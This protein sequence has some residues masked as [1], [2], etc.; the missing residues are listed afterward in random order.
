LPHSQSRGLLQPAGSRPYAT[1]YTG[2]APRLGFTHALSYSHSIIVRGHVGV[3]YDLGTSFI[4]NAFKVTKGQQFVGTVHMVRRGGESGAEAADWE[5][6]WT[7]V[8]FD[9]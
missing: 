1:D 2:F 3:F 9:R 7:S 4:G 5:S 6:Y 8:T